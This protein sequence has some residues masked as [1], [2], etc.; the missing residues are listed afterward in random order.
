LDVQEHLQ[1]LRSYLDPNHPDY[2]PEQQHTKIKAAIM[3]Y[4][5]GK[6]DGVEQV[7]IKDGKVVPEEE[8]FKG[9]SWSWNEGLWRQFAQR[10]TIAGQNGQ[11]I[12]FRQYRSATRTASIVAPSQL[13]ADHPS[14]LISSTLARASSC[15]NGLIS[16]P[17]PF[18]DQFIA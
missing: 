7:F 3:L 2:Q 5:D 14:C 17:P 10:G 12:H 4:E 15:D 1:E 8:A 18:A 16:T 13:G 6:I 11:D 9:G